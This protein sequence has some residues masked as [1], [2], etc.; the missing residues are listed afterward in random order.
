MDVND[1]STINNN[2]G[3]NG[4][5]N[6]YL[7][8]TKSSSNVA[9]L[10]KDDALK[11]SINEIYNK[12]RDELSHTLKNLNEGIAVTQI[13]INALSKQSTSLANVEKSLISLET[14]GDYAANRQDTANEISQ[15]LNNF[16]EQAQNATYKKKYLLDDQ[17]ADEVLT[18]ITNDKN[19]QINGLNT[20]GISQEIYKNLENNTLA[21]TD[22]VVDAI[23]S[24]RDGHNQIDSFIKNYQEIQEEMKTSARSTINEQINMLKENSKTKEINFGQDMSDFSKTNLSS[25][26]G[27]LAA[28][29]AHIIQEQ[30]VKLLS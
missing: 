30:S 12:K 25:N 16:N 11:L 13:S 23:K 14:S 24:V 8:R 20:K 4:V 27:F 18:I 7:D 6:Q 26:L 10:D 28:S 17:Y 21:S 3:L 29:Q 9:S 15:E 19:F 1:V 22:E 2:I 5:P